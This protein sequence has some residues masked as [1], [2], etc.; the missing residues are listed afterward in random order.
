MSRLDYLPENP[1]YPQDF[2]FPDTVNNNLKTKYHY[3]DATFQV[4]AGT[5]QSSF[6]AEMMNPTSSLLKNYKNVKSI[7]LIN[8]IFHTSNGL[9]TQPLLYMFIQ[10]FE[11]VIDSTQVAGIGAFTK[12][13]FNEITV[14]N[15]AGQKAKIASINDNMNPIL[16]WETKGKR[17]DKMTISFKLFG[18]STPL[19]FA[20]TEIISLTFK[21]GVIEPINPR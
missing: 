4:P 7:E 5:T 15:H 14:D 13:F 10:E 11:N 8:A 20:A 16:E 2:K 18:T 6:V 9:I 12:L 3:L 21:I 17:I 19:V 1:N